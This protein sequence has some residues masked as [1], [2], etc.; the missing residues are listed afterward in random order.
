MAQ[1]D[2]IKRR[3]ER[4]ELRLS[5]EE[6]ILFEQAAESTERSLSDWVR[7]MLVRAAKEELG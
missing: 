1:H 4:L 3:T 6:R 5:E 2:T 7:R